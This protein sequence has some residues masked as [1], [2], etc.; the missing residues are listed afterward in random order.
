MG[1]TSRTPLWAT[2]RIFVQG[3]FG[4]K[5]R[6]K[7]AVT[8]GVNSYNRRYEHYFEKGSWLHSL[9]TW[10]ENILNDPNVFWTELISPLGG[11]Y[12]FASASISRS[13]FR[14]FA[15][16]SE[17]DRS[18]RPLKGIRWDIQGLFSASLGAPGVLAFPPKEHETIY[19]VDLTNFWSKSFWSASGVPPSSNTGPKGPWN[20]KFYTCGA[21][22][23]YVP[24]TI[25]SQFVQFCNNALSLFYTSVS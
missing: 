22:S 12:S 15:F 5:N 10:W 21:L 1:Y 23:V 2:L 9:I 25:L 18:K 13:Y 8:V 19:S 20:C 11:Y 14:H 6:F 3:F 17:L 4:V 24:R 16:S 7:L